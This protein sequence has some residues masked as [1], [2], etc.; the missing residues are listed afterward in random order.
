MN[1][2]IGSS[3]L[4]KTCAQIL[5]INVLMLVS[6]DYPLLP[7]T[8]LPH[9]LPFILPVPTRQWEGNSTN[10]ANTDWAPFLAFFLVH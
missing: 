4:P 7:C 3:S 6:S 8:Q 2:P 5:L 1:G 10:K 9:C